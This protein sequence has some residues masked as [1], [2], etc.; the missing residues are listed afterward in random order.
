MRRCLL[1]AAAADPPTAPTIRAA[2]P[3]ASA[4]A[5]THALEQRVAVTTAD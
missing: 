1:D 3:V 4:D 5:L 2:E